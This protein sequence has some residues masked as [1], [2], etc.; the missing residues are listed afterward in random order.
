[1]VHVVAPSAS[2]SLYLSLA[3][4]IFVA[5]FLLFSGYSGHLANVISK[6]KVL[7]GVKVFEVGVTGLGLAA[8]FSTLI[9]WMLRC[10]F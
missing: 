6:R 5:P 4:A 7:I 10:S 3:G 1:V 8:F 9:E 2:S